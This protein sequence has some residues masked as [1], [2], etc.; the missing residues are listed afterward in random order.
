MTLDDVSRLRMANQQIS[1]TLFQTVQD[2][3]GWLGAVQAQDYAMAKWAIGLRLA[4][5]TDEMVEKALDNGDILRTHILR[6]TWHFVAAD[7]I[8]W[9]LSISGQRLNSVL[10][11]YHKPLELDDSVFSKSYA[12]IEKHLRDNNHLTREEIMIALENEGIST[13]NYRSIHIMYKAEA[14]GIVCSGA[15]RGT[16]LT[17]ALLEER[18]PKR[19]MMS[20]EEAL[21]T[22]AKRYFTSH[23][24]A[25]L[26]DFVWWSGFTVGEAKIGLGGLGSDFR[27]A[28]IGHQKYY[29]LDVSIQH[30]SDNLYLL[31]AFDEYLVSYKDRS[32]S[33]SPDLAKKAFTVNGIFKPVILFKGK[34]IGLWKRTI[35]KDKVLIEADFVHPPDA[36]QQALLTQLCEQYATFLGK[37][38]LPIEIPVSDRLFN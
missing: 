31:P 29:F 13:N 34:A 10:R 23:G 37:K 19:N 3:V 15:K 6:P 32:A 33:M 22:L 16:Q 25:T 14:N 28:E 36:Q 17:Y 21:A 24:P 35:K 18:V 5:M 20:K 4:N 30:P 11:T 8:H 1:H 27:S 12:I 2:M 9:M 26:Q 7:D 38:S